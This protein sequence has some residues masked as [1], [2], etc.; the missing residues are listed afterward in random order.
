[1]SPQLTKSIINAL[2]STAE[3]LKNSSIDNFSSWNVNVAG[4]DYL[5]P[6][7]LIDD[8]YTEYDTTESI[9]SNG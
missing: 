7:S 2:M 8:N 3:K 4:I 6:Y 9:N 5:Q 1:M